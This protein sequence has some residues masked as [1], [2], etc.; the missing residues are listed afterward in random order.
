MDEAD[1]YKITSEDYADIILGDWSNTE[2]ARKFS[3]DFV[4]PINN[5][6]AFAYIPMDR[7]TLDSINKFGYYSIPGC[8]G[9]M[10]AETGWEQLPD[11]NPES[12]NGYVGN[13]V[14]LGFVDTGIDYRHPA[15]KGKDN[16]TRI[17]SIWDQTINSQGY[18]E[19]LYYGTEYSREQINAALQSPA[20]LSVVPVTDNIGHGTMMAGIACGSQDEA[21]HFQGIAPEAEL[22]IV[23]LK[24]AKQYLKEIFIIPDEVPCYQEND[25][26][27]GVEYLNRVAGLLNRPIVICLGVGNNMAD[28]AGLRVSSRFY[29]T[30]GE[31]PGFV[32][33]TA[34]GNEANRR[35]HYY[36][37]IAANV[38][39]DYVELHVGE[40]NPG[41]MM[42]FWGQPPN[43]FWIDVYMPSG[44]FLVR[45]PPVDGQ[46]MVERRDN[47]LVVV[48]SMLGIPSNH[49]QS[50]IFRFHNPAEGNWTFMVFGSMGDL[51][52][53]FHFWL[54]L[55]NF[56]EEGTYFLNPNIYT[57]IVGPANST[58]LLTVT[59][60]DLNTGK[61]DFYSSR[62]LNVDQF[63]KPDITAPGINVLAPFPDYTYAAASGSSIAAAYT[64][65][66]TAHM[67]QWGVV[68]GRAA[69][70]NTPHVR[71]IYQLSAIR[72]KDRDYP[73][74]DWGYGILNPK[75]IMSTMRDFMAF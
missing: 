28:H 17:V 14:L 26:M 19:G 32:F 23:K 48:D 5:D 24:P 75:G 31:K 43:F 74:E 1:R 35:N 73:N 27:A 37:N 15:F 61:L 59:S 57:T 34:A 22:V 20:P 62:G 41:F 11:S 2:E 12:F 71:H 25:I 33:V 55:H 36:G 53:E 49:N 39:M 68:E 40:K 16:T 4:N 38:T 50:I 42:Q 3:G 54:T 64:A 45:I 65:G 70:L 9:L 69:F 60:Y 52:R 46:T 47:M 21:N 7:M 30:L 18:P 44:E 6:I 8:Y 66:I 63:L 10:K 56:L 72:E 67:L 58:G 29:A 51:P 13:G